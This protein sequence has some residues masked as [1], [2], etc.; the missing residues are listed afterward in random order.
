MKENKSFLRKKNVIPVN[1]IW[2]KNKPL[3]YITETFQKFLVNLE[4]VNVDEKY[5][6]LQV[7]S[8]LSGEGK[9]TFISNIC[10]LLGE[11]KKKVILIDLDL[12]RPKVHKIF[13]LE[14]TNGVTDYLAG[15][16]NLDQIIK[17]NKGSK[18]DIIT[19]GEK[20]T[21]ITNLLES[22]KL[23]ELILEL[24]KNYD[25][26]LVDSPPVI[27]V[28]DA[29]YISKLTDAVVYALSIT[30]TKRA[31]AKE[32]IQLLNLN[33]VKIV[34]IVI[35]QL[36]LKKNKYGYSYGYGYGY[37]YEYDSD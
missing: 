22:K 24:R 29:L 12:R 13:N 18:F 30:K 34:G 19:S 8:S 21:T 28:S 25:Y 23:K 5:N 20:T 9:S 4:Y 2:A 11:K 6:V 3:S 35:T 10:Y 14:N 1:Y 17:R 31:F 7:T 15:R 26:V 16:V 32:G 37:N 36:D 33:N 27:N